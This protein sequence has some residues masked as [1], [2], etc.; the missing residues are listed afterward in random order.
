[1]IGLLAV[2]TVLVTCSGACV[3]YALFPRL[4]A[5]WPFAVAPFLV[6]FLLAFFDIRRR[7]NRKRDGHCVQCGY[8]LHATPGR[9]PECGTN[10]K[11]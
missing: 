3:L 2:L 6:L 10:A 11:S 5:W 4:E 9:C 1:M 7:A 8:D